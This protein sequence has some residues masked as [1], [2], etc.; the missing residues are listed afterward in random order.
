MNHDLACN[1]ESAYCCK[2]KTQLETFPPEAA[3]RLINDKDSL[4]STWKPVCSRS[5]HLVKISIYQLARKLHFLSSDAS[6][7]QTPHFSYGERR[8]AFD[9]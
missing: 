8:F 6:V 3:P 4:L 2:V 9:S 7:F 5:A 1:G